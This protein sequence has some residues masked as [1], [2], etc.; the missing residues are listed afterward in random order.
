LTCMPH[1]S[2]FTW[3]V[4]FRGAGKR[5]HPLAPFFGKDGPSV[6]KW[7]RPFFHR[8][9]HRWTKRWGRSSDRAISHLWQ[10]S[11][12]IQNLPQDGIITAPPRA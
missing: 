3:F 1:Q 6:K 8:K 5:V 9:E 4:S 2:S 12:A 7:S 10:P 11:T